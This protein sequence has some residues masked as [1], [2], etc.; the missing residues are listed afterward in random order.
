MRAIVN[1][2]MLMVRAVGLEIVVEGWEP[3]KRQLHVRALG[4]DLARG[5]YFS[6]PFEAVATDLLLN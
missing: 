6:G 2:V 1:V 5:Y 3:A 4:C